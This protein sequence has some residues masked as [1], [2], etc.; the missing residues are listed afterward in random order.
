MGL[1]SDNKALDNIFLSNY[2]D[3]YLVDSLKRIKG[4]S[5]ARIFGE[6]RYAMRLW[7]DPNKLASRNLTT[8]DVIVV[9]MSS[10]YPCVNYVTD[11]A[12]TMTMTV[13]PVVNPEV[14][15][16][17]VPGFIV[18]PG[19]TAWFRAD[20]VGGGSAPTYQWTRNGAAIPGATNSTYNTSLVATGDSFAC[21]VVNTDIC[22]NIAG[23]D[24]IR[25]VVGNNIGVNEV[26]NVNESFTLFPNPNKGS[27]TLKGA[28][29]NNS[30]SKVHISVSNMLGQIVYQDDLMALNGEISQFISLD[31]QLTSGMYIM[32][33][34]TDNFAKTIHFSLQR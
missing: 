1:Y 18:A 3:L 7:L 13:F 24:A 25:M 28:L 29:I 20:V 31:E 21:K 19:M 6:R 5:E 2:A 34:Q 33:L 4:V 11:S 8:G 15:V 22:S 14:H 17:V 16:I 27:F 26:I 12:D 9:K 30:S 32:Q 10:S 23:W